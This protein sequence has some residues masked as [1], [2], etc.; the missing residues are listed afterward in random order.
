[1][2]EDHQEDKEIRSID[3]LGDVAKESKGSNQLI[4]S[5]SNLKEQF[6][7]N[8]DEVKRLAEII[9]QQKK[10]RHVERPFEMLF[11]PSRGLFYPSKENYLLLNQLTYIEENLL[12]SE[13]LVES[14]KAMEFVLRNILVEQNVEPEDLLTGDVEAIGLFLR[15]LPMVIK[16]MLILIAITADSKRK[17]LLD[18]HN[19]K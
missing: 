17:S 2:K 8:T 4:E 10:D 7:E 3:D 18:Y 1:M 14:G 13:F 11:I 9:Q 12:T 5:V 6:S 16:W 19:F 15:S